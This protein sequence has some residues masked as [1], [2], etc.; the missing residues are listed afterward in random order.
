MLGRPAG[1]G[2]FVAGNSSIVKAGSVLTVYGHMTMPSAKVAGKT[3]L[4]L[5][6]IG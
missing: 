2:V 5:E 4:Q 6:G 3:C 1:V